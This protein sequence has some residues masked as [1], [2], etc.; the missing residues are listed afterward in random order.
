MSLKQRTK[1]YKKSYVQPLD[2]SNPTYI[3]FFDGAYEPVN[4]GGTSSYGAV[5]VQ[6]GQHIWECSESHVQG[7]VAFT[8]LFCPVGGDA[9][10]KRSMPRA[11]QT[12]RW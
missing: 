10:H 12:I 8:R 2:I 9:Y 1:K 3:A 6:D 11:S 5:I 4:P 7:G